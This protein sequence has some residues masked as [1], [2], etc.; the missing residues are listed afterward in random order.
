MFDLAFT[1]NASIVRNMTTL[2]VID[3]P[4]EGETRSQ[5]VVRRLR[6]ELAQMQMS[7][8][9][10]AAICGVKQQWFSR[11]M[12]GATTFD[13]DEL[14]MICQRLGLSFDYITTGIKNLPPTPGTPLLLPRL[15]SNQEPADVLPQIDK[16]AA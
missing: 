6:G 8:N 10:A 5:V 14:D 12:I 7:V 3:G 4:R 16:T 13:L 9:K 1:R 11:R 15:D 2:M